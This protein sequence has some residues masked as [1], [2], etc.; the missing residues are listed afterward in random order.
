MGDSKFTIGDGKYHLDVRGRGSQACRLKNSIIIQN[1][2]SLFPIRCH[3]QI[4]NKRQT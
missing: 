2:I 4:L 1:A 3:F